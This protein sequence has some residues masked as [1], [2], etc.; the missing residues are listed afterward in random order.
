MEPA[1]SPSSLPSP[2]AGSFF[3]LPSPPA[4]DSPIP[5]RKKSGVASSSVPSTTIIP[6][7]PRIYIR[8]PSE[9]PP[10]LKSS[11]SPQPM[12]SPP[13]GPPPSPFYASSFFRE[14]LFR[15]NFGSAII[16]IWFRAS[17]ERRALLETTLIIFIIDYILRY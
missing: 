6:F 14:E 13:Q 5:V 12:A 1:V 8:T 10:F 15:P 9:T 11:L 17:S 16:G 7:Y 2:Q 4:V 3:L